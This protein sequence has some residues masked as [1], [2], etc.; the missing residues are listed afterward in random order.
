MPSNINFLKNHSRLNGGDVATING[1]NI[2]VFCPTVSWNLRVLLKEFSVA[3]TVFY[4]GVN[5]MTADEYMKA[6]NEHFPA[7]TAF[8]KAHADNTIDQAKSYVKSPT[9]NVQR[10]KPK[11][12]HTESTHPTLHASGT[13]TLSKFGTKHNI[14]GWIGGVS[15]QTKKRYVYL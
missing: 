9:G 15:N 3:P 1:G 4:E 11:R 10:F 5:E 14:W 7:I 2:K 13:Y 12:K 8:I 6:V